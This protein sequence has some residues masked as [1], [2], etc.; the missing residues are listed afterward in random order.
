MSS[1]KKEFGKLVE[2]LLENMDFRGEASELGEKV[3]SALKGGVN[4]AGD[5]IMDS[6]AEF[7]EP[8]SVF[9]E[10]L[11]IAIKSGAAQASDQILAA[12]LEFV[13]TVAAS[14]TDKT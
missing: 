1:I 5:Q 4:L 3:L 9:I 13:Q 10:K 12:G 8:S 11:A 2:G 14:K 7:K 6:M